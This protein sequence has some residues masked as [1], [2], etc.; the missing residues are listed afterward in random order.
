MTHKINKRLVGLLCAIMAMFLWIFAAVILTDGRDVKEF[1]DNDRIVMTVFIVVEIATAIVA[2]LFAVLSGKEQGKQ[3]QQQANMPTADCDK[4]TKRRGTALLV[5]AFVVAVG[6]MIGGG[7]LKK[8]LPVQ[9]QNFSGWLFA[10]CIAVS[11]GFLLLSIVLKNWYVGRFEKQQVGQIQQ[12]VYSHR[13]SAEQTAAQKLALLKKWRL[14]TDI[15]GALLGVLGVCVALCGG[16]LYSSGSAVPVCYVASLLIMCAFSQVRFLMPKKAFVEDKAYI[17]EEQYP[18]LYAIAKKAAKTVGC[19]GRIRVALLPNC[20]AGIAKVGRTYSV[21]MGVILLCV[22][23]EAEVY[24]VLL[25]EFAHMAEENSKAMKERNYNTWIWNGKTPHLVS[26]ITNLFFGFTDAFYTLQFSLYDFASTLQVESAADQAMLLSGDPAAVASALLK[27]KYYD[28]FEWEK[29]TQDESC[30]Y[31]QEMPDRHL[32]T[33]ELKKFRQAMVQNNEKWQQLLEVEIQSRSASHPTLHLRLQALGIKEPRLIIAET[34]SDYAKECE[35][36]QEY[37]DGL[38]CENLTVDYEGYRKAY[39]LEPKAQ[40]EEW[41]AAGRPLVAQEYG[42]IVWALRQLGRTTEAIELCERAIAELPA[43]ASCNGYF[44]RGCYRLHSYDERGIA[45][46]YFAIENNSNYLEEG[47]DTIG[48]FCCLTG[49]KKEL[50]IYRQKAVELAQKHKD[51]YSQM[52]VLTPKDCLSE[53]SLPD[54]ML[55]SIL[56][57]IRS[58]DN[59]QIEKIYLVRKTI[60]EDFFTS[61]FVIRFDLEADDEACAKIMHKLYRYLDT[62]S[63]WQ[64]SLFDYQDVLRVPVYEIENSCVYAKGK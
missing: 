19:S 25:H 32:M 1:T 60:T 64:F 18:Q 2:M 58:M 22:L 56:E 53:E 17:S 9:L 63:D 51:Q 30:L 36:A 14:F 21:Q 43:V 48:A 45:D 24:S 39:Y 16:I 15:Y 26:G 49:N 28:L 55:E 62:C 12:F 42:D 46:I 5:L 27:L 7:L 11:A 23:S 33:T 35:K 59:G 6:A 37:L 57:Y 44:M 41:E 38:L 3:V 61:V 10:T 52:E 29:G 13:E 8:N 4:N 47:I 20:N 34:D 40:V 50:D 54:G 31:E